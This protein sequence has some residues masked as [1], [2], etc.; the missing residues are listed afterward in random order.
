MED[1][2]MGKVGN[3]RVLIGLFYRPVNTKKD[4]E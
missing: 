2:K 3:I 4:E 1:G